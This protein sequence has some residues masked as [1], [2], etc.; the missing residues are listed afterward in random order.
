MV[1]KGKA[2]RMSEQYQPI[3]VE[4]ILVSL[5]SSTHSFSALKAAIQLAHH[6]DA[7][8]RGVYIQ[9]SK[10]LNL[11]EMSWIQEVGGYTATTRNISSEGITRGM[12]VQ[13]RWV[14]Q[15]FNK[16]I[17]QTG[18]TGEFV[19]LRGNVSETINKEAENCDLLIA[20]KSGT[21]P[22][23][24]PRLGSTT[25]A[26]I[27]R[28]KRSLLLV[29][30]GN[31]VGYPI[32][33]LFE[34][35]PPGWIALETAR[36]LLDSGQSL[37]IIL[38]SDNNEK[39]SKHMEKIRNWAKETQV[40]IIFQPVK[41][42]SFDRFLQKINHLKTGLLVMPHTRKKTG[43]IFIKKCLDSLRLPVFLIRLPEKKNTE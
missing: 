41:K 24:R 11:A 32:F 1:K 30:E 7:T 27:K 38:R 12:I 14:I 10:L 13:S 9:D 21:N 28:K 43:E 40:N 33:V 2:T 37:N 5:D 16:M 22:L 19:I 34:N 36:D 6:Y 26:L 42:D 35:S 39:F 15:K 20:G 18:L 3:C 17:N 29:E 23:G 4:K 8:I 31:R 25:R